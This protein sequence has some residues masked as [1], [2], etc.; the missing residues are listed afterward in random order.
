MPKR[1]FVKLA[2]WAY[3]LT[4]LGLALGRREWFP[5]FYNPKF[6]AVAALLS[7][8][9]IIL[10]ELLFSSSTEEERRERDTVQSHLALGLILNGWGGLGLYRLYQFGFPY[11]KLMHFVTPVILTLAFTRF[12]HRRFGWR[13]GVSLWR[14]SA[15]GFILGIVWELTEA[16]SDLKFGTQT[17]GNYR[18]HIV[19]DTFIDLAMNGLGILTA[20]ILMLSG[21]IEVRKEKVV[22]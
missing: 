6:M 7:G 2:L 9:I 17:W 3:A 19:E 5:E 22:I 11:D 4:A 18:Q 14:T 1:S 21:R 12:W 15:A 10:P 13:P 20:V 8:F 16:F